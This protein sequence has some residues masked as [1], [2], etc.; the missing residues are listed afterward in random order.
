MKDKNILTDNNRVASGGHHKAI[1]N[2]LNVTLEKTQT[3]LWQRPAITTN[4]SQL[5]Q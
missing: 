2:E 4:D 3:G 1:E 5:Q